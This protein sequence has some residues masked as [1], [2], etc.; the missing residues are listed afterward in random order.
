MYLRLKILLCAYNDC[1]CR[2]IVP[3]AKF[4]MMIIIVFCTYGA[5]RFSGLLAAGMAGLATFSVA[6]LVIWFTSLSELHLLSTELL[7]KWRR[8]PGIGLGMPWTRKRIRALKELKVVVGSYYYVDRPMVAT[9]IM[10]IIEETANF[11]LVN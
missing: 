3:G 8:D 11:L 4:A 10:T 7:E 5:V 1:C 9:M 2:L 6:V